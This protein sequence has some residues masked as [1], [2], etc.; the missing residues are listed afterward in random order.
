MRIKWDIPPEQ[1]D[2]DPILVNCFEGLQETDHPYSFVA[3]QALKELLSAEGAAVKTPVIAQ[4]L[5]MPLRGALVSKDMKI[6]SNGLEA[7]KL[8]AS[9]AGEAL[10]VHVHI[11]LASLNS[12]LSDKKFRDQVVSVLNT[13]E[14]NG[15]KDAC[16]VIK[17]KVPTYTSC[18]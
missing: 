9:V 17:T 2:Y 6:F 7:L 1:L 8:L 12:K 11:L 15:G 5:V 4:R 13:I 16:K 18:L 3:F 14:R 10:L